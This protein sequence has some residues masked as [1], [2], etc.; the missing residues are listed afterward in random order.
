[1]GRPL[2]NRTAFVTGS[3]QGIGLAIAKS[4]A[5][6][7][8]NI[9]LHGLATADEAR[10]AMDEM[11]AAGAGDVIFLDAD[12]RGGAAIDAMIE[13]LRGW[14]DIDILVSNAGIQKTTALAD[15]TPAI[16]DAVLAV[17]LS[18]PFHI[19]R[20]LLPGM[21]ARGFGRVINIAS[22]H[23]LVASKDKA[24]YVSSKF[25]LVGLSRVAALEYASAGTRASGGVTVNCICPGWTETA[26]IEPQIAARAAEAG[27][28]EQAIASL[29]SEKQPSRRLSDPSEIGTL[30]LWLCDRAAH[31]VTGISIPV[32]GGWTAQ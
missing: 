8:A 9:A 17:N 1:M 30:C 5:G 12:L 7:G 23:G 31:N 28:R 26:I 32:D 16:W 29:L 24:P 3:V 22:V 19:M 15:A 4:L 14:R 21:G 20:Q 11:R 10:S 13:K 18:A 6:A 2:E 27:G 25:G